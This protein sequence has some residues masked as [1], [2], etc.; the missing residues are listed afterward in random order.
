MPADIVA[1]IPA[2]GGSKGVPGKNIRSLGGYPLIAYSIAAARLAATIERVV[3]S[4]DSEE[5]AAI[6]RHYGGEVPFLRPAEFAGDRSPDLAFVQ[7][8]MRWFQEHEAHVPSCLVHLR[9]TTPL[10]DPGVIDDAVAQM[11]AD[12]HATSLRSGHP[13]SETPFKWFLKDEEGY[14]TGIRPDITAEDANKPRQAFPTVYIPNGYVDVLKTEYIARTGT[15]H[16]DRMI[17]FESP[18]GHEVDSPDDFTYLE[19]VLKEQGSKLHDYLK[20]TFITTPGG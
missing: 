8:A 16:G 19:F 17:G 3:I 10:R 9:P 2:R 12:A 15:L 5:I 13:A 20:A 18:I 1:I 7:H 4:T 14:F 11:R 6:A